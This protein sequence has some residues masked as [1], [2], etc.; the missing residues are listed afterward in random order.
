MRSSSEWNDTATS[1]PPGLSM[2]S[3]AAS[4]RT[5]SP[6]SSLTK[7]RSA[8]NVRVAGWMSP[9]RERTT[10][11]TISASARVVRIG[12]ASRALTMAR[13]TARE[14]RSSP[15]MKMMLAR[16]RSLAACTTSAALGAIAAHAHVERPVEAEGEAALGV[17]ELHGGDAEIEHHAVDRG[18][19]GARARC[20]S[21]LREALLDQRQPARRAACTRSAPERDG[22]RVAVDGDDLAV[23]GRQHGARVAAGAESG[24]DIDAAVTDIEELER[25]AA[26]HGNV[27]GRSASDSPRAVAARRHSRAPSAL[28]AAPGN[29]ARP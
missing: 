20:A 28:R 6:S 3:A 17:I 1:R 18:K 10:E 11:A 4:A 23:G 8:W 5:S 2:R 13:A 26:E 21:R 19:A 9:G 15:S 14:W 25:G 22:A 12:A 29:R 7:M 16:S 27:E 24:V